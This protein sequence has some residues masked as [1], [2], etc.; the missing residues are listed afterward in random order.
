MSF[1]NSRFFRVYIIPGAVFQ[2]VVVAGGYGTGR[3]LVE[4]FTQ[5]GP[6][7]G[8]LGMAVTVSFP[9]S[10]FTLLLS[11]NIP[12]SSPKRCPFIR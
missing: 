5:Y 6:T 8:I 11:R 2:S 9:H 3:E 10:F 4:Y 12:S 7:G 1:L